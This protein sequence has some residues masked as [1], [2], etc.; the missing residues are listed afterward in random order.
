MEINS[1]VY[2]S[3][4]IKRYMGADLISC[5]LLGKGANGSV[6]RADISAEP[7]VLAIKVTNY[8]EML[9]NEVF[10]LN[11]IN[12]RVDILLPK[13]FFSHIANDDIPINVLGMTYLYG[14]GGNKINWLFAGKKKREAFKRQV[15]DNLIK[16][17][18]VTN[19]KFGYVDN[20]CFESW[21]DFYRPFAKRGLII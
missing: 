12:G 18:D 2:I 20:A 13:V 1:E 3:K 10:A 19:E 17:R 16:L 14:V 6:Y 4:S 15:I 11:Y 9:A 5:K 21:I 7:Y 8:S